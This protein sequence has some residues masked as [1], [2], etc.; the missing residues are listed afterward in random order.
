MKCT[1][2]VNHFNVVQIETIKAFVGV[3]VLGDPL[4]L[5]NDLPFKSYLFLNTKRRYRIKQYLRIFIVGVFCVVKLF[6]YVVVVNSRAG[7]A[8]VPMIDAYRSPI[9]LAAGVVY[10]GKPPGIRE[11]IIADCSYAFR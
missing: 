11:R 4:S 7:E 8:F 1:L 3:D 9:F 10:V 6:L 2:V 5:T